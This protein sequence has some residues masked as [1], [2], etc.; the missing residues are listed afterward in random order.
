MIYY[1]SRIFK[2]IEFDFYDSVN[3]FQIGISIFTECDIIYIWFDLGFYCF[4]I[5]YKKERK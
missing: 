3:D 2:N 4:E 1:I 5:S